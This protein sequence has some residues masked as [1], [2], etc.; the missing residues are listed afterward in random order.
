[1]KGR[2]FLNDCRLI[3]SD[4]GWLEIHAGTVKVLFL[5]R[6]YWNC[7]VVLMKS[8][9]GIDTEYMDKEQ[10]ITRLLKMTKIRLICG[11]I[12]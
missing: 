12:T 3:S 1:M 7:L 11:C 10:K 6:G 2:G 4:Y 9:V 8:L 5:E